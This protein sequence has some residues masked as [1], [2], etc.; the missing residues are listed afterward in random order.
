MRQPAIFAIWNS[1]S[2]PLILSP[3][4]RLFYR[5]MFPRATF[6]TPTNSSHR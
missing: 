5:P 4:V 2:P 6:A 1:K 3:V